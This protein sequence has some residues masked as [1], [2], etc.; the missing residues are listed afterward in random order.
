MMHFIFSNYDKY[1][2][3]WYQIID[4]VG[5]FN[6]EHSTNPPQ[7]IFIN[8]TFLPS[9]VTSLNTLHFFLPQ[10]CFESVPVLPLLLHVFHIICHTHSAVICCC[11]LGLHP[12]T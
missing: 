8:E 6:I 5:K 10:S 4:S 7:L 2:L 3:L 12:N 9:A 1:I 11:P